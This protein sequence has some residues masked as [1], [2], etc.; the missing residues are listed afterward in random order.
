[1]SSIVAEELAF[2]IE[3]GW[4]ERRS[5]VEEFDGDALVEAEQ[6]ERQDV[7]KASIVVLASEVDA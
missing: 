3:C 1:M 7:V 2:C 6:V 4:V 5:S